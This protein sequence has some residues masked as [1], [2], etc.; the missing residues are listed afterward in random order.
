[1]G[2]QIILIFVRYLNMNL[3]RKITSFFGNLF[4][5]TNKS[6]NE[7]VFK[8]FDEKIQVYLLSTVYKNMTYSRFDNQIMIDVYNKV[9]IF[10]SKINFFYKELKMLELL[11]YLENYLWPNFKIDNSIPEHILSIVAWVNKFFDQNVS[12]W[13]NLKFQELYVTFFRQLVTLKEE[14]VLKLYEMMS[15]IF[16]LNNCFHSFEHLMLRE[17]VKS[18]YISWHIYTRR[19]PAYIYSPS[20]RRASAASM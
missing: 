10:I 13:R 19:T 17:Q 2:H 14:R 1:M 16:F 15:C 9:L 12:M 5:N 7:I 3:W 11:K 8:N 6:S 20:S 4:C 18:S